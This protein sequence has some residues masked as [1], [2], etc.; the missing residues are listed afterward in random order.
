M[1][2][3]GTHTVFTIGPASEDP[4]ASLPI[5]GT[6]HWSGPAEK[7]RMSQ[8]AYGLDQAN[9]LVPSL[10]ANVLACAGPAGA[11]SGSFRGSLSLAIDLDGAGKIG[12]VQVVAD[13]LPETVVTCAKKAVMDAQFIQ[14]IDAKP[15]H[16]VWTWTLQSTG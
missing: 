16:F 1:E 10:S 7:R 8:G 11:A 14:P 2:G 3:P 9:T 5:A 13:S 6:L 12:G 15:A 4:P